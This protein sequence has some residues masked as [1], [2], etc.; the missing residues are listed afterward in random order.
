MSTWAFIRGWI[1]LTEAMIGEVHMTIESSIGDAARFD[2]SE[3]WA[4]QIRDGW[5]IPDEPRVWMHYAFYGRDVRIKAVPFVRHQMGLIAQ[6]KIADEDR[7]EEHP[8][9]V[10]HVD[11][12]DEALGSLCVWEIKS[13]RLTE[14]TKPLAV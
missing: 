10:I 2:I 11:A 3:S 12:Q 13:G 14:H 4:D 7:F 6:I 5:I 8:Q 1:E 9:G